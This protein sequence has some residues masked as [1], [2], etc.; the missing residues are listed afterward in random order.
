MRH[1]H[2]WKRPTWLFTE[3]RDLRVAPV[4][5]AELLSM[6]LSGPEAVVSPLR[7]SSTE[8]SH[9]FTLRLCSEVRV[10]SLSSSCSSLSYVSESRIYRQELVTCQKSVNL[11]GFFLSGLETLVKKI[12]NLT[13]LYTLIFNICHVIALIFKVESL[14]G[15]QTLN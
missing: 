10:P 12:K 9:S 7:S 6:P 5:S 8:H 13:F 11:C 1:F 15:T 3:G 2:A 14:S 4:S